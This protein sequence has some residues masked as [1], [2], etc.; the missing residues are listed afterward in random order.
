ML[1]QFHSLFTF[2]KWRHNLKLKWGE[3]VSVALKS[4]WIIE[5][6]ETLRTR[7]P[8]KETNIHELEEKVDPKYM[9]KFEINWKSLIQSITE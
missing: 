8:T 1:L 5:K 2:S 3:T 6:N 7:K 4:E 9:I